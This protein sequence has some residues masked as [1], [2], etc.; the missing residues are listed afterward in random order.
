MVFAHMCLTSTSYTLL[1]WLPTYFKETFPHAKVFVRS[2]PVDPYD[3]VLPRPL[4]CPA[5]V[6][7]GSVYNVVPWLCAIPL[8]VGGGYV[9]DVLISKGANPAAV[10]AR[11]F[12]L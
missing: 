6:L 8:A 5:S 3:D 10:N 11:Y 9:S 7:Q 4:R 12:P 1:S 2:P